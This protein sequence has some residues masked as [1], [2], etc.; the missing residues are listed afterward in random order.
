MLFRSN[1]QA[2]SNFVQNTTK[3]SS[4]TNFE[5]KKN[6]FEK[7][8]KVIGQFSDSFI[9]TEENNELIIYDQHIVHERILY[10]KLKREY[11]NHKVISQAL[12]VPIKVR[13]DLKQIE[14]LNDKLDFFKDF[15]FEIDQ[16]NDSEYLI[17]S[18]PSISTKD[19]FENIFFEILD[20]LNKINSKNEIIESMIIS[21][22]CRGAVKANEKLSHF[23]MEKLLLEL[24]EIGRFTCPHGRPIT[25]KISLLDMEKG[26]KRK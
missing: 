24:H 20:G 6:M 22:S 15:G 19:S 16:F 7:P 8:F 1:L 10:E 12:L 11:E 4:T 9:L 21:M 3:T 26:F 17:R 2:D 5:V 13:L 18:V 23:E 14:V 25:F